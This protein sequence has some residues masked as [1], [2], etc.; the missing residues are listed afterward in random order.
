MSLGVL[1]AVGGVD[2]EPSVLHIAESDDIYVVR[3]CVDVAD[4]L[5]TAAT[6]QAHAAL[7]SAHLRGL[8]AEIVAR[9]RDSG[10]AVIGVTADALSADEALLRRLGIGRVAA[11]DDVATLAEAIREAVHDPTTA[12]PRVGDSAATVV[13][14]QDSADSSRPGTIIAVWG[15]TGAPGRS[16]VS[17]GLSAELA[18]SGAA[19]L[20][21]DADVYGGSIAPMLGLLDESSGLLAAAR[22]ANLGTLGATELAAHARQIDDHLKVLTG[23]PRADRWTEVKAVLFSSILAVA[24]RAQEFTV[25][26]CGFNLE[27]DEEISYDTAAPRRN[28]ATV[29]A[30]E[31]A[32]LIIVVGGADPVGLGRLI[33]GIS[34]VMTAVPSASLHV[35]VNRFRSGL[36]WSSQEVTDMVVRSTGLDSVRLLPDD[37]SACDRA[38]V[39]GRTLSESAPDSSLTRAIAV[40]AAEVAGVPAVSRGRRFRFKRG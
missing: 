25:V 6:R 1:V 37:P 17:L 22:A 19:T 34:E 30:L 8:D 31:Q 5:A 36:G 10:V 39:H 40:M 32:D 20:L 2:F 12:D 3:R 24:R 15:P 18:R 16:V 7:V 23:L 29:E 28:G 14:R 11:S 13:S 38:L 4:L 35:V 21:V 33:R 9:L 26:D 27:F